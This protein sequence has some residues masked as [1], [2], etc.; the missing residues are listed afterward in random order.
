MCPILDIV[1]QLCLLQCPIS[2]KRLDGS[3]SSEG[4]LSSSQDVTVSVP[5][6]PP[7]PGSLFIQKWSIFSRMSWN[8]TICFPNTFQHLSSISASVP[9]SIT[10]F[11]SWISFTWTKP[12]RRWYITP[13]RCFMHYC[14]AE[15]LRRKIRSMLI[16][17]MCGTVGGRKAPKTLRL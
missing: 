8:Q 13:E 14:S 17:H 3:S 1:W 2:R 12:Q 11:L 7:S 10:A 4:C 9:W 15:G 6:V 5:V 16:K